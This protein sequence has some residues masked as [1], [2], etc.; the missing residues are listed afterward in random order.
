[1]GNADQFQPYVAVTPLG[2][3][4]VAYFDRRNDPDNFFIDQYL[5][6]STDSGQTFRDT[7]LS[8]DLWDPSIN[9]PVSESGQF[10]GDYQAFSADRC[11]TLAFFNDTHLA[12]SPT[13]DSDFDAGLPRSRFQQVL[14]WRYPTGA[15]AEADLRVTKTDSP[16]PVHIGQP[17]TYK[18]RVRNQGISAASGVT[19][20]D[21]LPRSAGFGSASASQGSCSLKPEKRVVSCSLGSLASGAT[22]TVTIVVKP[23]EKGTIV[24]TASASATGP[25]DPNPADNTARATTTVEP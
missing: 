21:Q 20:N 1:L 10:I 24:N 13:R 19:V 16:D 25:T 7:R 6:R 9:P 5:S 23:N 12:N 17:L 11:A 18:V 3:V 22:A 14:A 4:N 15:C 2:Q 8:H